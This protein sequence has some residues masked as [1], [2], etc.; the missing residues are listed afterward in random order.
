MTFAFDQDYRSYQKSD[1]GDC[2]KGDEQEISGI[3]FSRLRRPV[4]AGRFNLSLFCRRLLVKWIH[5]I[6]HARLY[7]K[8]GGNVNSVVA[9]RFVPDG[10]IQLTG[11]DDFYQV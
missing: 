6:G 2:R 9:V 4:V 5:R 8:S 10:F 11:G 3:S 1:K 7:A